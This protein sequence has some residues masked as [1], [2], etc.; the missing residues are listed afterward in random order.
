MANLRAFFI[1]YSVA[2]RNVSIPSSLRVDDGIALY[3]CI[4]WIEQHFLSMRVRK[5]SSVSITGSSI[6]LTKSYMHV[7]RIINII[8][9]GHGYLQLELV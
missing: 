3:E 8:F 7:I 9:I 4:W 1:D 6:P 2:Y 5:L